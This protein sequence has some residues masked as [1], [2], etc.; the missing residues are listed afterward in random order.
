MIDDDITLT[1][2]E[3]ER[4]LRGYVRWRKVSYGCLARIAARRSAS[5]HWWRSA[6]VWAALCSSE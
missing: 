1:N 2:K 5:V 4:A 3:A 6:N